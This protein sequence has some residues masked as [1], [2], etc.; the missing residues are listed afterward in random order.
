M[1]KMIMTRMLINNATFQPLQHCPTPRVLI[2]TM[3]MIAMI[4]TIMMIAMITTIA[5]KMNKK[6]LQ[7]WRD[8]PQEQQL[9]ADS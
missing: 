7:L 8:R 1:K 2:I 4:V 9:E 5:M 3:M 6:T